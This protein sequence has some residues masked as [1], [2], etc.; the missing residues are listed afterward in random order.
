M[1]YPLES[2]EGRPTVNKE[3]KKILMIKQN[4]GAD[5]Y[6]CAKKTYVGHQFYDPGFICL[7]RY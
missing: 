4:A 6:T 1:S 7:G 3:N 5:I 2:H